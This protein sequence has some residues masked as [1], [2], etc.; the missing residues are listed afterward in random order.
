MKHRGLQP[1]W[2]EARLAVAITGTAAMRAYTAPCVQGGSHST[3]H[4]GLHQVQQVAVPGTTRGG[5]LRCSPKT[6][7]P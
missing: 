4:S 5:C 1:E 6:P 7:K 3:R 2:K